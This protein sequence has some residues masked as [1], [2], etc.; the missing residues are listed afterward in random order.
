MASTR[1]SEI[2]FCL[3][4][5]GGARENGVKVTEMK[6][7]REK[8]QTDWVISAKYLKDIKTRIETKIPIKYIS[9]LDLEDIEAVLLALES[10][11]APELQEV[12]KKHEE[13]DGKSPHPYG[14]DGADD[15]CKVPTNK[16]AEIMA[17]EAGANGCIITLFFRNHSHV[18]M[19]H[20][21]PVGKMRREDAISLIDDVLAGSDE[22]RRKIENK[23]DSN[24]T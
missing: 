16:K 9:D 24:N 21:K 8:I 11:E 15:I 1:R 12:L 20:S 7:P 3:N 4:W 5:R 14:C 6:F 17:R 2:R 19:W 13:W 23:D 10:D 18:A 22:L